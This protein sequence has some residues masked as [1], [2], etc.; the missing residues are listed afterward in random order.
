MFSVIKK[1][2]DCHS[3]QEAIFLG[4]FSTLEIAKEV[5]M[6]N[7]KNLFT[8]PYY[9]RNKYDYYIFASGLDELVEFDEADV[10]FTYGSY[11]K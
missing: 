9:D 11:Y 3:Y 7:S 5:V 4:V 10:V 6:N 1:E 8:A 2:C